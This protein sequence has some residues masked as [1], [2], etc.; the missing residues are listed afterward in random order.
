MN[1]IVRVKTARFQ[2]DGQGA[3]GQDR[4]DGLGKLR[5]LGSEARCLAGQGLDPLGCGTV[6]FSRVKL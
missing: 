6:F 3:R 4:A 2:S 1:F 5:K